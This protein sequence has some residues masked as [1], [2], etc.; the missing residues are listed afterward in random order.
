MIRVLFVCMGNIC[1]SPMA[2]GTF[3]HAVSKQGLDASFE[4]DSAGT[5]G[6]HAG[7]PPDKRAQATAKA[8]GIDISA[9]RSRKVEDRDFEHYDY[10][11]VMDDQNYADITERCPEEHKGKVTMFLSHAPHLPIDEMP[12]P[13]YGHG[14]DF[15]MC[16]SAAIDASDGLLDLIKSERF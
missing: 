4:I 11:L 7:S 13:Y 10:I 2:E 9:Q 15:D 3:R 14:N 1:R 12:D 6:Y 16:F 8:N 5:I